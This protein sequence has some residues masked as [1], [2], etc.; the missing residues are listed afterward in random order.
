MTLPW[1]GRSRKE[2]FFSTVFLAPQFLI[3]LELRTKG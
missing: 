1:K 2:T 3:P